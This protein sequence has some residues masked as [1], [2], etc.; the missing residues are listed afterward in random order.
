MEDGKIETRARTHAFQP[1]SHSIDWFRIFA[2]L[3]KCGW[4]S[5]EIASHINMHSRTIRTWATE[6]VEPRHSDGIILIEFWS[7]A[8]GQTEP[9]KAKRQLSAAK[10]R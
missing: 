5:P 6:G 9:P 10:A 2:D 7:W 4:T 8:T 3:R 1:P